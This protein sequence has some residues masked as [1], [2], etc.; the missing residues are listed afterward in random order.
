M[1]L[2]PLQRCML[3]F[4]FLLSDN[5]EFRNYF[6]TYIPIRTCGKA[7]VNTLVSKLHWDNSKFAIQSHSVVYRWLEISKDIAHSGSKNPALRANVE[8]YGN[9]E[10]FLGEVY[11]IGPVC[12]C[13]LNL[14]HN[15]CS[16]CIS[17]L[18]VWSGC[19]QCNFVLRDRKTNL[20][21]RNR[22]HLIWIPE[23]KDLCWR[24]T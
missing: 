6:W 22:I 12:M 2:F 13:V 23:Y 19:T 15:L 9:F 16:N 4:T 24:T 3:T 21:A 18:N 20:L 17:I 8:I 1:R 14:Q 5:G 11:V 7:C 10:N